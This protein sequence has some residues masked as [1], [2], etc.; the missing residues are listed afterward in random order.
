MPDARASQ[1]AA[2]PHR[3]IA[4]T[5]VYDGAMSMRGHRLNRFCASLRDPAN[6]AAFLADEA[7]YLD[8]WGLSD[9]QRA[10]VLER[11]WI[12]L[13][14][15]GLNIFV[16]A[17]LARVDGHGIQWIGGQMTGRSEGEFK[18]MLRTGRHPLATEPHQVARG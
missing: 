6:R 3:Q 17:M 12:D 11:R 9:A 10:A 5:Y 14:H 4:G 18:A 1:S 15:E 7:A 16:G 2:P 8:R 13:L